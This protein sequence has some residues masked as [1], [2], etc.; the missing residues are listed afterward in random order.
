LARILVNIPA[1]KV[2]S[3]FLIMP[4]HPAVS[5]P[6]DQI[7]TVICTRVLILIPFIFVRYRG[8]AGG[9]RETITLSHCVS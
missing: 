4:N 8:L 5:M 7:N 3:A 6:A 1:V 9:R 2:V